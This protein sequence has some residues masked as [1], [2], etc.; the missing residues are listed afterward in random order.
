MSVCVLRGRG[1]RGGHNSVRRSQHL[2]TA[3]IDLKYF[4]FTHLT[5]LVD[6]HDGGV[7]HEMCSLTILAPNGAP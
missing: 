3:E 1:I 2:A 5:A 4:P 6:I 7:S